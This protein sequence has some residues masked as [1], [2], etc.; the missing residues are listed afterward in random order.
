MKV[1]FDE[2]D[3]TVRYLVSDF[4][5]KYERLLET[6]FYEKTNEGYA[7]RYPAKSKY[8]DRMM[9]R[10]SEFAHLMFDQLCYFAAVPWEKGLDEFCALLAGSGVDWWLTGSCAACVRGVPLRPRD[11]DVIVDSSDVPALTELLKDALIEPIAD[12]NGWLTK[13]FGAVFLHCRIKI[14]SDPSPALD[15]PEP[16]DCGPHARSLLETVHWRGHA[17]KVPPLELQIGVNRA[18]GRV[19]R[20]ELMERFLSGARAQGWESAP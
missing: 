17:I 6:S 7:K 16:A 9:R 12:T 1:A 14:A 18:R 11:I 8:L 3:G 4:E 10:Y 13:D 5:D 15:S 2:K 20:V 19:D